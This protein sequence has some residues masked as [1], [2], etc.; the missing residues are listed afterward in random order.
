MPLLAN[1]MD[2]DYLRMSAT[3]WFLTVFYCDEISCILPAL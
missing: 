1:S 2:V 3:Y